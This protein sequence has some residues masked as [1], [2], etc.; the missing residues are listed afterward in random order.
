MI[1]PEFDEYQEAVFNILESFDYQYMILGYNPEHVAGTLAPMMKM[2]YVLD[3]SPM[4]CA[5]LI[6][7]FTWNFQI[8]PTTEMMKKH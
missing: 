3:V 4:M 6:W 5:I 7:S 8:M 2:N 1:D